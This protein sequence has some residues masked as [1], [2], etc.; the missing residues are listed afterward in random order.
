VDCSSSYNAILGRA[1]LN[2]WKA[3]TSTYHLPFKF[4]TKYGIG[5]VQGDKLVARECY[6]A[7][8]VMDEQMQAINIEERRTVVEPIEVLENVP[9]DKSNLEKFTRIWTSKTSPN[10]SRKARTF[11]LGA[12]KTYLGLIQV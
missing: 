10:S 1:T 4:P 3:A 7:M 8:L 5:E 12:T 2:S 9:L 11:L 6:L